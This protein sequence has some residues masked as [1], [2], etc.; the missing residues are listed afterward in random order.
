M[1]AIKP[2]KNRRVVAVAAETYPINEQCAVP[3][4]TEAADD[5]HHCFPRSAIGG[6]SYFVSITFDSYEEAVEAL[7]KNAGVTDVGGLG[8]VSGPVPHAIG[9][10]RP[11]H[12]IIEAAKA[13]IVLEGGVWTYWESNDQHDGLKEFAERGELN[14]QPGSTRGGKKRP[15]LKGDERRKRRT[16]SLRVPDDSENG[17]EVWDETIDRAKERLVD[18]ELYEAN[19]TIPA[20]ETVI[21]G[22]ND[23]LNTPLQSDIDTGR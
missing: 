13:K 16:I 19:A 23:W 9:L 10:C 18:A 21:A 1:T 7:G 6:D 15:R 11:H 2:I 4:C 8:W 22:L 5:P 14:P 12:N 3:D 20:Y 17:G